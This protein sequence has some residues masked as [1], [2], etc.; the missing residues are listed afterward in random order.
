MQHLQTGQ[1][2][3]A[4]SHLQINRLDHNRFHVFVERGFVALIRFSEGIGTEFFRQV[5][6]CHVSSG[7]F[8]LDGQI[9]VI[10]EDIVS[11]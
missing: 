3:M 9:V 7:T 6:F 10:Q 2:H 1:Q 8:Y 11:D 5:S 4:F